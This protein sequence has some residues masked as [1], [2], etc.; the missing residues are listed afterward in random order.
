MRPRSPHHNMYNAAKTQKVCALCGSP[1]GPKKRPGS[2]S[3]TTA[4]PIRRIHPD[5]ANDYEAP[6]PR[7]GWCAA[8]GSCCCV[9]AWPEGDESR[10]RGGLL[11]QDIHADRAD[12]HIRVVGNRDRQ[13]E[14]Q[15]SER[16]LER[17]LADA[18]PPIRRAPTPS[19]GATQIQPLPQAQAPAKKKRAPNRQPGLAIAEDATLTAPIPPHTG[20]AR[21]QARFR[22]PES[23]Q[24]AALG[25]M[26]P[27]TKPSAQFASP[28]DAQ[29]GNAVRIGARPP[30][31]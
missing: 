24:A 23:E 18:R 15:T 26:Q 30:Q 9:L 28:L 10:G 11:R 19:V 8:A 22:A 2:M 31:S 5:N 3:A 29:L 16:A 27:D 21:S 13:R 25:G 17:I 6:A 1:F 14:R 12:W 20:L 4:G 7:S